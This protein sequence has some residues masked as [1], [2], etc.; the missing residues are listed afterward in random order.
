MVIVRF[1]LTMVNVSS[2]NKTATAVVVWLEELS[3]RKREYTLPWNLSSRANGQRNAASWR[4]WTPVRVGVNKSEPFTR[5]VN[6][7]TNHPE[8]AIQWPVAVCS[9]VYISVRFES[10]HLF[11][12]L[13][14]LPSKRCFAS[15]LDIG[16][17][18]RALTCQWERFLKMPWG[19]YICKT[20]KTS[21]FH[22]NNICL[23]V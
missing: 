7:P 21:P 23:S 8:A 3:L 1:S 15:L 19:V 12:S 6:I 17:Y 18:V 2:L 5:I 11:L 13:A 20:K 9:A 14:N 10:F 4:S 22:W 16:L